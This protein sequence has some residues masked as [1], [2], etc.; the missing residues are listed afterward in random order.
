MMHLLG[1]RKAICR[2]LKISYINDFQYFRVIKTGYVKLNDVWQIVNLTLP[3]IE[4]IFHTLMENLKNKKSEV[5]LV[6]PLN[7]T[8]IMANERSRFLEKFIRGIATFGLT[9]L[10]GLFI[11]A[12]FCTP[13]FW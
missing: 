12:F 10:Y 13:L 4:V 7:Q 3:F 11:L 5:K 6:Q 9:F 1:K 8:K 2:R